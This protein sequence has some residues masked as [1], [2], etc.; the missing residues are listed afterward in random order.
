MTMK[1]GIRE[2]A[3]NTNI[4]DI[5]GINRPKHNEAKELWKIVI[6]KNM[7][8]LLSEDIL[9]NILYIFNY[10]YVLYTATLQKLCID[11]TS[12]KVL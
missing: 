3:R 12:T 7:E 9:T 5:I 11:K 6:F 8:I 4:L 2:L 10:P 1:V